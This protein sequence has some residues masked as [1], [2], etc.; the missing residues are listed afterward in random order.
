MT[1]ART[2]RR[3]ALRGDLAVPGDKSISHRALILGCAT[4]QPLQISNVNTGLDVVATQ[5]ALRALGGS[6]ETHGER[7]LVSARHLHSATGTIDCQNSGSTARLLMGVCAGAKIAA[8]FDGDA[9]LRSRP[10]EPLAAQLRAY[11]ARIATRDG[12]LPVVITP[13]ATPQTRHFILLTPSAQIKSA[14]LFCGLFGACEISINGDRGSRDHTERMLKSFGANIEHDATQCRY[15][16]TR[17]RGGDLRVPGDFSAAAFFIVAAT[18]APGSRVI[19]RDVG[20]NPTRTGLLDILSRMGARITV[21]NRRTW[22]GEPVADIAVESAKLRATD[23]GAELA[24]RAI[25]EIVVL[26][27]AAAYARGI[28][29]IAGISDLRSKESDRVAAIVRLLVCAGARVEMMTNGIAIQPGPAVTDDRAVASLGDHRTVMATAAL[30][31]AAGNIATDDEG[32]ADVSFPN[33]ARSWAAA[34][35]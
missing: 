30:A 9:S 1:A 12:S 5:R 26:S 20:V 2:F 13:S 15:R 10:M 8:T 14:L 21:A 19:V 32:A 35:S 34:Q 25:D 33:F 24:L 31:A 27:V 29:T 7:T 18:I 16:P 11:G 4:A 3:G 6:I 28:T 17:L 22:S 23:V